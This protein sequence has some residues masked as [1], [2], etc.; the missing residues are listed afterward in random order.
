M[1][2]TSSGKTTLLNKIKGETGS[3]EKEVGIDTLVVNDKI[4][5][6]AFEMAGRAHAT[7]HHFYSIANIVIFV[8]DVTEVKEM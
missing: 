6:I 1:G 8:I 2:F 4:K 7:W 5:L 3:F